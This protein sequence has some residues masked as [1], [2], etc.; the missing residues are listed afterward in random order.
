M[1]IMSTYSDLKNFNRGKCL[2]S[3]HARAK[4]RIACI[5]KKSRTKGTEGHKR[6]P[7]AVTTYEHCTH[8][9]DFILLRFCFF[10]FML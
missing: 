1:W 6:E 7:A 4:I 5:G 9:L 3:S 10:I 2:S 8:F